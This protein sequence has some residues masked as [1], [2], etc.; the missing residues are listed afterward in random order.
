MKLI[1]ILK[2]PGVS[3]LTLVSRKFSI[4]RIERNYRKKIENLSNRP[5]ETAGYRYCRY[6]PA[7]YS[8][9]WNSSFFIQSFLAE[10][11]WI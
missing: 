6:S 2:C 11:K 3:Y 4:S 9:Q 8:R 7:Y 5:I 10:I 1:G